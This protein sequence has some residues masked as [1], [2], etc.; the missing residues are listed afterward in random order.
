MDDLSTGFCLIGTLTPGACWG[1]KHDWEPSRPSAMTEFS[2]VNL[3][4]IREAFKTRK[5]DEYSGKM[6]ETLLTEREE[7]KVSGPYEA[8]VHWCGGTVPLPPV[9]RQPPD[10]VMPI[11]QLKTGQTAAAFAIVSEA[12]DGG[13][14]VRRGEDWRRSGHNATT[15]TLD[16]P[17]HHTVDDLTLAARWLHRREH[18]DLHILGDDHQSVYRQ[19]LLDQP[20]MALLLLFTEFGPTLLMN[21]VLLFGASGSVWVYGRCS[22]FLMHL[23]RLF[24][25]AAVFHYVD[26]FHGI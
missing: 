12:S 4:Y 9:L 23:C 18:H 20:Q 2:D 25:L 7:G 11:H 21:H 13:V 3:K 26:D 16:A 22:Y 6:L 5:P 1:K 19:L 8:P 17:H 14:K 10:H 15:Q 24:L